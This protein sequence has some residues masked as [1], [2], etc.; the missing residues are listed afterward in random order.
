MNEASLKAAFEE[1]WRESYGMPPGTH[2]VMTHVS[3]AA[4]VLQLLE[5]MQPVEGSEQ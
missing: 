2:A 4:H 1:W 3:F 5:L